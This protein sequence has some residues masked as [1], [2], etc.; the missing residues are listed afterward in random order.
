MKLILASQSP[1]RKKIIEELG[2]DIIVHPS[3]F[4][5][6][7]IKILDPVELVRRLAEE[8]AKEVAKQYD[9]AIII[10]ADTIVYH[11]NKILGQQDSDEAA[12]YTL[13]CLMGKT[14]QVSTGI[15]MINTRTNQIIIENE[16]TDVKIKYIKK[17][18]LDAYIS[19][20][21]YKGKAG[22]YNIDDDKFRKYVEE[23]SGSYTNIMGLPKGKFLDMLTRLEK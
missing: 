22:A 5:E 8:K 16:I 11:D 1:R 9:D 2:Y 6:D 10:A 4:D 23:Y 15:C 7:S 20:G 3:N 14:H 21:L 13:E 17:A 12:K 19:S 18:E